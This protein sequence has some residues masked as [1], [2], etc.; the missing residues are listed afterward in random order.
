[1]ASGCHLRKHAALGD[2]R[3][4][5][6]RDREIVRQ[7]AAFG[8]RRWRGTISAGRQLRAP[9]GVRIRR[10]PANILAMVRDLINRPNNISG[11]HTIEKGRLTCPR[12]LPPPIK[13]TFGRVQCGTSK[14]RTMLL[15]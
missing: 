3:K 11:T 12:G 8:R 13:E 2:K 4:V 6:E 14:C 5:I 10:A 1:L 7:V 15:R 9:S